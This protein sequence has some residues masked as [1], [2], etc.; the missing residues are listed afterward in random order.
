MLNGSGRWVIA[1]EHGDFCE[2]NLVSGWISSG[3]SVVALGWRVSGS[4][5]RN[6]RPIRAWLLSWEHDAETW[7]RFLVR[8]RLQ[9]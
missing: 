4:G 1:T 5:R 7:R 9:I 3:G 8:L 2:A 6:F